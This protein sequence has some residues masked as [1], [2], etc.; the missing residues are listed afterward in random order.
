MGV[1]GAGGRRLQLSD[2]QA[3]A[4]CE[5]ESVAVTASRGG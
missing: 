4:Q 2:E 1:G 3:E 5:D